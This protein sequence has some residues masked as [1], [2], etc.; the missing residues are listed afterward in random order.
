MKKIL[1]LLLVCLITSSIVGQTSNI[2]SLFEKGYK[3]GQLGFRKSI[4]TNLTYLNSDWLNGIYGLSISKNTF[5]NEGKLTDFKVINSLSEGLDNEVKSAITKSLKQWKPIKNGP[6]TITF[7][8]PIAFQFEGA[9]D[10]LELNLNTDK[11]I[12][13]VIVSKIG[14]VNGKMFTGH[15]LVEQI[16][17]ALVKK[18]Y[19]RT[20]SLI[21]S[22]LKIDP[23]NIKMRELK[24]S[25]LSKL[26][27]KEE[28]GGEISLMM[29]YMDN[30][31]INDLL[32]NT[33]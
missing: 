6:D 30:K 5:T 14:F 10:N 8:M 15:D 20:L 25:Y 12:D 26:G 2:D 32:N 9:Y 19:E 16:T 33:P 22:Y 7:Y 23:F 24:I 13:I 4:V 3:G 1:T 17:E 21:N 27:K 29:N 18:D 11:M 31:S 28:I